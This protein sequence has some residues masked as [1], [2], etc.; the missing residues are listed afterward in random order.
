[1]NQE[2]KYFKIRFTKEVTFRDSEGTTIAA[3]DVG[4]VIQASCDTGHYFVTPIGGI[5]HTEAE[6]VEA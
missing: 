5:Y 3:F 6:K 4:D 2:I 1:M